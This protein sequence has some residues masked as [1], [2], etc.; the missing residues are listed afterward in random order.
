M[1]SDKIAIVTAYIGKT[2][3]GDS[4]ILIPPKIK[5]FDC[6]FISN[7]PTVLKKAKKKDWIPVKVDHPLLDAS[8]STENFIQNTYYGKEGKLFPQNFVQKKYDILIWMDNKLRLNIKELQH[9]LAE[10]HSQLNALTLHKH[11]FIQNIEEEF[12]KSI[13]YQERYQSQKSKYHNYIEKQLTKNLSKHNSLHFQCGLIIYNMTHPKTT[14]I[15]TE[16]MNH[17]NECGIQD[18]ISFNFIAQL[19]KPYINIYN[20]KLL[21]DRPPKLS[22]LLSQPFVIL[23]QFLKKNI[24]LSF[25]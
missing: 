19:Y 16:W 2:S 13:E 23:Y 1:I 9:Y 12:N 6:Y 24:K 4:P 11:P 15:Q 5:K 18:Q 7:N 20:R 17:I 8:K 22:T 3:T 21:L 25:I 10:N 14:V